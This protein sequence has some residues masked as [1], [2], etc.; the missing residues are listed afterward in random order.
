MTTHRGFLDEV[1]KCAKHD[2]PMI[3]IGN[4]Y[5]CVAEYLDQTIGGQAI[6]DV[7][8]VAIVEKEYDNPFTRPGT[9]IALAFE[10]R[11]VMPLY[12]YDGCRIALVDRSELLN[13]ISGW[14]VR[15]FDYNDYTGLFL[16][17]VPADQWDDKDAGVLLGGLSLDSVRLLNVPEGEQET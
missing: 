2:F 8:E 5:T 16:H 17:L 11:V 1:L 7:V 12:D 4:G 6:V 9:T 15:G 14:R 10:N 13:A 3:Y